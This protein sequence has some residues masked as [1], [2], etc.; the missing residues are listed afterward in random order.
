MQ[1]AKDVVEALHK[2]RAFTDTSNFTL[3][4]GICSIGLTGEKAAVEHA[5]QTGHQNFQEYR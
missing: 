4:C 3:R 1:A 2:Q 5:K